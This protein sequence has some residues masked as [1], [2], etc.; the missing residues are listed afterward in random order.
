MKTISDAARVCA[1]LLCLVAQNACTLQAL[2]PPTEAPEFSTSAVLALLNSEA[3]TPT[4]GVVYELQERGGTPLLDILGRK[5]LYEPAGW[6][7]RMPTDHTSVM[8]LAQ[9][10]VGRPTVRCEDLSK[11][12]R[13]VQKLPCDVPTSVRVDLRVM[14]R[15]SEVLLEPMSLVEILNRPA[16]GLLYNREAESRIQLWRSS[17]AGAL[18]RHR[19]EGTMRVALCLAR[20]QASVASL[21]VTG[22]IDASAALALATEVLSASNVHVDSAV[23]QEEVHGDG[24][25]TFVM[26]VVSPLTI[27][28]TFRDMELVDGAV[29]SRIDFSLA[30]MRQVSLSSR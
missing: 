19:A 24:S 3:I 23:L 11:W 10:N 15:T 12:A 13:I 2:R 26:P 28:A 27:H 17:L 20:E 21:A 9:K 18:Y 4:P 14:S 29:D 30:G 25:I 5:P 16:T 7:S 6:V 1:L 22:L 8:P